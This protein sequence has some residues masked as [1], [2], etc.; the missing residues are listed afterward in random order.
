MGTWSTKYKGIARASV[1]GLA[2]FLVACGNNSGGGASNNP[3]IANAGADQTS[4]VLAGDAVILDGSASSDPDGQALGYMWS[5]KT[6]PPGSEAELSD[7][8]SDKPSFIADIAGTYVAGLT[9]NDGIDDSAPD[10]TTVIVVVPPPTVTIV[11]P[12]P[13]SLATANPVTV[14]GTVDDPLAAITVDGT[15][16]P[17][18]DGTYSA[19]VTLAEGNN[20]VMVVATNGTGEGHASVEITLKTQPGPVMSI[21]FPPPDFTAGGSFIPAPV[22][23]SGIITTDGGSGPPTVTVHD[24]NGMPGVTAT[25]SS[26]PTNLILSAFCRLFPNFPI[27]QND[28]QR[29]SFSATIYLSTFVYG[30]LTITAEGKDT[31]GGSAQAHVTGVS[32]F[33]VIG[34]ADGS[35][36][37]GTGQNNRCHEIDGCNRNKFGVVG[38]TDTDSLRNQPMPRAEHNQ[39]LVEFGS[40]YILASDP[41]NDF[42]VHGQSPRDPLGCNFH[43]TCYQT[44]VPEEER[45][46]AYAACNAEQREDH[47]A[48]CRKAYPFCPYSGLEA[49]ISCPVWLAEKA[50]CFAI[51]E[52]Y[53]L[54]VGTNEGRKQY[55]VRQEDYC[56]SYP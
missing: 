47:K 3:P 2:F 21:T 1:L 54:G 55:E 24:S 35:A 37:Q 36:E 30:P 34:G 22:E 39:V 23:V 31:L 18:T 27:C 33:C 26:I 53:F 14:A 19:D 38:S 25:V 15:A 17:N 8:N 50:N 20:T 16:T 7:S 29:Y 43:D 5:L 42:F 4:N 51:A 48:M 46:D 41:R 52:A 45:D 9:V 13:L 28:D 12:E 10:E 11:T 40:G 6:T 32:D 49:I 44:C 56:S